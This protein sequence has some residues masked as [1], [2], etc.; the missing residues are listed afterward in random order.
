MPYTVIRMEKDREPPDSAA[1][2]IEAG[3]VIVSIGAHFY[4]V[5]QLAHVT[6]HNTWIQV[7]RLQ[8]RS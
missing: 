5:L 1:V 4:Y 2:A 6:L 3:Y 7:W 8:R